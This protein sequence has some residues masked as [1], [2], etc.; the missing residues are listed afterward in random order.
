LIWPTISDRKLSPRLLARLGRYR[1]SG[2]FGRRWRSASMHWP[3][4]QSDL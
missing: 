3:P 1:W 2:L 4:P